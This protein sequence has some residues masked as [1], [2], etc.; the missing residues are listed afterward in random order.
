MPISGGTAGKLGDRYELLWAV[1]AVLRIINM[2]AV[3]LT[4]ESLDPDASRGVEFQL[5]LSDG[6]TEFWSIKRQTSDTSSWTLSKLCKPDQNTGRSILGD[7]AA[8][9]EQNMSHVAV[10]ASSVSAQDLEE[11]RS[12][13]V[14]QATFAGRIAQNKHYETIYR[15]NLLPL[16]SKDEQRAI[17]FLRQL[18][19]H[20][21]TENTLLEEVETRCAH[22]F[23][24]ADQSQQFSPA[25]V[26]R[27]IAEFLLSKLNQTVDRAQLLEFL[28]LN[29]IRYRDWRFEPTI[30]KKVENLCI[31][32]S[33]PIQRQ[34]ILNQ[35]QTLPGSEKLLDD[36]GHLRQ[37]CTLLVGGAGSGKSSEMANLVAHFRKEKIPVIPLRFDTINEGLLTTDNLGKAMSLPA[38]PVSV[39]AGI[40]DGGV[41]VLAVDQLD[42]ISMASGRRTECWL[43]FE[44]MLREISIH[45]NLKIIVACRKFD[46]END[47]RIRS[48]QK[49][50]DGKFEVVEIGEFEDATLKGILGEI[51]VHAKLWPMLK[52]PLHLALFLSLTEKERG[53]LETNDQLLDA[54]WIHKQKASTHRM[55]RSCRFTEVVDCLATWL[56]SHQ[57]LSAPYIILDALQDDAEVLIS[58]NVLIRTEMRVRFFHETFFDYAFA[59]HF[60]RS[61]QSLIDLLLSGEQHL[62]RRAQARQVLSFLRSSDFTGYLAQLEN[63]LQHATVRFH[64]KKLTF[65]YLN[66]LS[67]PTNEEWN[68]LSQLSIN[69]P[70]LIGH[71]RAVVFNHVGWF[72][73]LHHTGFFRNSLKST[74]ESTIIHALN[75]FSSPSA[76]KDRSDRIAAMLSDCLNGNTKRT[77]YIR[78]IC[79]NG[80]VFHSRGMFD[81][82]LASIQDGTLDGLNPNFA[83][84]DNW[85]TILYE[86]SEKAP[87]LA[88]EAIAAWFDRKL[89]S[90]ESKLVANSE[91]QSKVNSIEESPPP[92]SNTTFTDPV[93]HS[94]LDAD[95]SDHGLILKLANACPIEFAQRFVPRIAEF[96]MRHS[97]PQKDDLAVDCVWSHRMYG[98]CSLTCSGALLEAISTS[99]EA[100]AKSSSQTLDP[101]I[102]PYVDEPIDCIA[103]F[104]LRAWTSAPSVYADRMAGYLAGDPRRLKIGYSYS[105]GHGTGPAV[106]E[107]YR[108]I[109]AVRAASAF[110]SDHSY[111]ALETAIIFLK[112]EWESAN[113]S[114]RGI[115]QY[116]L[117]KS[118]ASN[119]MSMRGKAKFSE[120]EAKFSNVSCNPPKPHELTFIGSPLPKAAF[121]KMSDSHWLAA[122]TKFA[123][124]VDRLYRNDKIV[125]GEWQ[126]SQDLAD[127]AKS[128]PL[129]FIRL[130]MNMPDS[131]P[132]SYFGGILRGI[133]DGIPKDNDGNSILG[134]ADIDQAFQK[135]HSLPER[136]CGQEIANLLWKH[137]HRDWPQ[138]AIDLLSWYAIHDPSP[139]TEVWQERAA[140]G[141]FYYDGNPD[142]YGLNTVRGH[143]AI[144]IGH[145]LFDHPNKIDTLLP[146][147]KHLAHDKSIAVRSQAIHPLIALLNIDR[148]LA[149]E[150]FLECISLDQIL[151]GTHFAKEFTYYA[152]PRDYNRL[153]AVLWDMANQ[154]QDEVA[155]TGAGHICLVSLSFE[156]AKVDADVI[157]K[158]RSVWRQAAAEVY[159]ENIAHP[160]VGGIC[161][162]RLIPFLKDTDDEVRSAAAQVFRKADDLTTAQQG[163]LLDAFLDGQPSARALVP[164]LHEM[165]DSPIQLPNQVCRLVEASVIAYTNFNDDT[166][167][168][169]SM[170]VHQLSKLV[171]RLYAQSTDE[172]IK[173]RCLDAIDAMELNGFWG[174]VQELDEIDR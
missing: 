2:Q 69:L 101:L 5:K 79:K 156:V 123:G 96:A 160:E 74:D 127:Q 49:D 94:M 1:K 121:S 89:I 75:I 116:Q 85:W 174:L 27:L 109:E 63:L 117:M 56:S 122:M 105:S 70:D 140:S 4:Y 17:Q 87:L 35:L 80:D 34:L 93:F 72:D 12:A 24:Q 141:K 55:G 32:Y 142:L 9:T 95:G 47:H 31:S 119:R 3:S 166:R 120:L 115:R 92:E 67:E 26:R 14:D 28:A 7:L 162:E 137:H 18:L 107:N 170:G 45:P 102:Q 108:S 152:A 10:F 145:L 59:R 43:I 135:V 155:K 99:L 133:A 110:C 100:L 148:T 15:N 98:E 57:A 146:A 165:E 21:I 151:L 114:I 40:A 52:T 126:I 111:S 51:P 129:R 136:P 124:K 37:A 48:L 78:H 8:K 42:A 76:M 147:V 86:M 167:H 138:S 91:N 44:Q 36:N 143:A 161:R 25:N 128:D 130:L 64:I 73:V 23:Y 83:V 20:T 103:Y 104:I 39:L 88:C 22:L 30:L 61:G 112:D 159:S 62:F 82:F 90:W 54:F 66:S 164:V 139:S 29:G 158:G 65:R 163:V 171:V 132:A 173:R 77:E 154:E 46:L 13:S 50:K 11:L 68:I 150:L 33:A 106:A 131:L 157:G 134:V 113:P 84:N 19:I 38:S 118:L 53:Q 58:E 60:I 97:K 149:V 41:G 153:R 144:A 6:K 71:V 81:L 16:F 172:Q 125:G 169:G 168:Y